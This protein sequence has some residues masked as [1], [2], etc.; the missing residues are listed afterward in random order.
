MA[1]HNGEI[2]LR[3]SITSILGQ[4]FHDFEFLIIDDAS[5][6]RTRELILS[7]DDR[8][9]RLVENNKKLG[10]TRTLNRGLQ[11]ARGELIAR[12]DADDVSEPDRLVRQRAFLGK[13]KN[14]T[15]WHM[16]QKNR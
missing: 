16:V 3:E 13:S 10:Q 5:T 14:S 4:S 6:D 8:R 9:I 12:Q 15:S 11:L 2:H 7:Y 1:V